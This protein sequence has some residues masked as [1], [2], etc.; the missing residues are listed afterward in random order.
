VVGAL[1]RRSLRQTFRRPQFLA[2]ILLFPTLLLAINTGGAGSAI[3]LPSFPDVNGFLDFQLAASTLQATLLAAVSGG[4][5][6]ALDFELGFADRLMAAPIPR[7]TIVVGRLA[8]TAMM[9]VVA[10]SW[11]LLLGLVFGAQVE[12]G[13]AGALVVL[14]LGG[15]AAAAFG[16][17]GAALAVRSG[18]ASV[19][20]GTFPLAFVILYLSSAFFP[21]ELMLEPAATAA[22]YNPLS[23]IAEALRNPVLYDLSGEVILE[24]LAGIAIMGAAGLAATALAMRSRVKAA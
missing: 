11:F 8:G 6:L 2:P 17:L 13:V 23:F 16:G 21:E 1:A 9:G 15:L 18:K 4:V 22:G 24:G 14:G 10:A 5:A 20:Q 7:W 3:D 12:G 19:V